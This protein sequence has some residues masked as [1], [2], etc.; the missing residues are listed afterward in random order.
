MA[1][2]AGGLA[3]ESGT[4]SR[5]W[6]RPR[7][8][9]GPPP[10]LGEALRGWGRARRVC[11]CVCV[12]LCVSVCVC[13]CVCVSVRVGEHPRAPQWPQ[14]WEVVVRI[15]TLPLPRVVTGD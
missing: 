5:R 3:R 4:S 8:A 12:C 15:P 13:V 11:V 6:D 2:P 1:R 7:P 14:G 10:P 9:P